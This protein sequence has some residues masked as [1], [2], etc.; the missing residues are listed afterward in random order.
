MDW[1]DAGCVPTSIPYQYQIFA[2]SL[3][4]TEMAIDI[5]D[6]PAFR[7]SDMRFALFSFGGCQIHRVNGYKVLSGYKSSCSWINNND[8]NI[9]ILCIL[10]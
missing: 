3:L 4:A 10:T 7:R 1:G 9:P 8:R 6:P 2:K 5:I